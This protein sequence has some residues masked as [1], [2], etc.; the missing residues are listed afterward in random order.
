MGGDDGVN[1]WSEEDAFDLLGDEDAREEEDREEAKEMA[2]LEVL[3]GEELD[4]E[5]AKLQAK[6][7][8]DTISRYLTPA[9][10]EE[11]G[12]DNPFGVSRAYILALKRESEEAE[13][14]EAYDGFDPE[15]GQDPSDSA[16]PPQFRDAPTCEHIK[17]TNQRCGS[18][19]LKGKRFCYYHDE[20]CDGRKLKKRLRMPV[21]EDHRSIQMALTKVCQ[22]VADNVIDAKRAST[23]FYGLQVASSAVIKATPKSPNKNEEEKQG[24]TLCGC[25]ASKFCRAKLL[26]VLEKSYR[27]G[28]QSQDLGTSKIA[29]PISWDS[30]CVNQDF[31]GSNSFVRETLSKKEGGG[32]HRR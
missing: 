5:I 29:V 26:L 2:R 16:I 14:Q 23:L 12:L 15:A 21:L 30:E 20:A 24:M 3:S 28:R 4:A 8:D 22:R 31:V 25:E 1:R 18:P 27:S 19:A 10:C 7:R 9:E 17:A 13:Q 6:I 32:V 11:I